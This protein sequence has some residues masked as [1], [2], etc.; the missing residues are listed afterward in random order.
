MNIRRRFRALAAAAFLSL[1][2][3]GTAQAGLLAG[4]AKEDITPA[5]GCYLGGYYFRSETATGVHDPLFARA[6]VFDSGGKRAA[7][8]TL[9]LVIINGVL[10]GEVKTDINEKLGIPPEYI[11]ISATHTHAGPQGYYE[12]YGKYPKIF[13]PEMKRF[14][15]EKITAA[16]VRAVA[17]LAPASVAFASFQLDGFSHNRHDPDGPVDRTAVLMVVRDPAGAPVAGFL[18]FAAHPTVL[19]AGNLEISGD[20][21]GAFSAAMEEKLGGNAVFQ[22]VQGAAGNIGPAARLG[23]TFDSCRDIAERM[24]SAVL[25]RFD[26]AQ[27]VSDFPVAAALESHTLKVKS[28]KSVMEFAK[29]LPELKEQIMETELPADVKNRRIGWLEERQGTE[30]FL[31]MIIPTMSRVRKGATD[32]AVQVIRLGPALVVTM[33]GEAITEFSIRFREDLK[34]FTVVVQAYAND[35]LG[36]IVDEKV[37]NEGGYEASM[38]LVYPSE[39]ERLYSSVLDM[40]ERLTKGH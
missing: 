7:L 39:A 35:H 14:M 3:G 28:R 12:E 23:G 32:T 36:Y 6:I 22:L 37:L 25:D 29:K 30:S 13:D 19:G 21:A 8:V 16:V 20:W 4:F 26:S 34:P 2:S 33:P 24:S 27:P 1:F 40:A 38:S 5:P 9:D 11:S 17:S 10:A 31:Q 18:N 15:K